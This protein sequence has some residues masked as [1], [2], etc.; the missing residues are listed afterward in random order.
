MDV[1]LVLCALFRELLGAF[2]ILYVCSNIDE[3]T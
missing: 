2:I 3:L 1:M